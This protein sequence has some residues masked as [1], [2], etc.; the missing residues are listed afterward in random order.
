MEIFEMLNLVGTPFGI[1]VVCLFVTQFLIEKFNF[2]GKAK[3]FT[4]WIVGVALSGIMLLIGKLIDFGA[5]AAFDFKSW[6]EWATFSLVALSPGLISN[7]IFSSG[8]LEKLLNL[9]KK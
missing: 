3:V 2:E 1:A 5:Y 4:S 7:G 9:I 6:Q 8:L